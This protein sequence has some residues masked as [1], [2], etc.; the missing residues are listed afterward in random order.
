MLKITVMHVVI[1]TAITTS[2]LADQN[3]SVKAVITF[4]LWT[5]GVDRQ[6]HF[7]TG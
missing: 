3:P 2:N 1:V 5:D 6:Q 4:V 7:W